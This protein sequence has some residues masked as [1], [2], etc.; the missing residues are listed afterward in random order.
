MG[1]VIKVTLPICFANIYLILPFILKKVMSW[2]LA[3]LFFFS[4]YQERDTARED[5]PQVGIYKLPF[6][7]Q[8]HID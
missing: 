5:K 2:E 3:Y 6:F 1:Y 4:G 8:E 7:L